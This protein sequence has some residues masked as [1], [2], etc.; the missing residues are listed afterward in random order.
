MQEW[1]N[2][3]LIFFLRESIP[4]CCDI[5]LL[6]LVVAVCTATFNIPKLCSLPTVCLYVLYVPTEAVNFALYN[7]QWLV[8]ITE[9]ANVYCAVRNGPLTESKY[10]SFLKG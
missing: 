7:T 6:S 4:L 5:K 1:L 2:A 10:F 9:M 3:Q 8:F